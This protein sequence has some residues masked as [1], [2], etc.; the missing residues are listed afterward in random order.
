MYAESLGPGRVFSFSAF[1]LSLLHVSFRCACALPFFALWSRAWD[2]TTVSRAPRV[3]TARP[4]FAL[5]RGR[6]CAVY[7]RWM[8]TTNLDA[9]CVLSLS[10][11]FWV[12]LLVLDY[13]MHWPESALEIGVTLN[14][15]PAHPFWCR[16]L[17]RNG[18][19]EWWHPSKF[20][21]DDNHSIKFHVDDNHSIH[22]RSWGPSVLLS[23]RWHTRS[24][25]PVLVGNIASQAVVV[26]LNN[27]YKEPLRFMD[28]ALRVLGGKPRSET[29]RRCGGACLRRWRWTRLKR[30]RTAGEGL[31]EA[32]Q[33]I[34]EIRTWRR[35]WRGW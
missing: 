9:L 10:A 6:I 8:N 28:G 31:R 35:S 32:G 29:R 7:R 18:H 16:S 11:V 30:T 1:A 24:A 17:P 14:L 34:C 26:W 23:S 12:C 22:E 13:M 15:A 21:V 5:L 19:A 33:A 20:H 25:N 27:N 4:A 2:G 3:H